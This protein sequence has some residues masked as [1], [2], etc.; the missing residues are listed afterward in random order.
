M[1]STAPLPLSTFEYLW[2]PLST[3]EY[4]WEGNVRDLLTQLIQS[5]ITRADIKN[6]YP[7]SFPEDTF[8]SLL[9]KVELDYQTCVQ[10]HTP[11]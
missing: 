6:V 2:V 7:G 11:I 4:L 3:F 5:E 8:S 1:A 10:D 9:P